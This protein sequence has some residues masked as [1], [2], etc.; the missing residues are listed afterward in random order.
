MAAA[1]QT[2]DFRFW[3]WLIR[4]VG[5]IVPRGLRADWRQ[6]WEAELRY[7][8]MMLAEWD[9]LNWQNK[10]DLFWRSL[11]AFKDALLL[12]PKRLE[13]EM[14]QDLRF[15]WR[16]LLKQKGFTA[17]AVLSLALGIGANTALFSLVDTVLLRT[18]PVGEPEQLVL[19]EWQA[20]K[21]FRTSG[22]RGTFG[23][24][25]PPGLRGASVFRFDTFEKLRQAQAAANSPLESLFAFAPI[26]ELT[27]VV[28]DQAEVIFGQAVTGGYY[29][30]LKVPAIQGRTIT[31]SDDNLAAAPVVV[32]SHQYWLERFASN[33]A[34]IGQQIKLNKHSF[35]IIG[36]TPPGFTGSGQVNQ[37]PA[38]TVPLAF[39]PTLLGDRSAQSK[40]DKP[41]V[42]WLLMMGRL[43]P[44]ATLQQAR[45]SLNGTFEA[46]A[47]EIMPPPRK[48]TE[49]AKIEAKDNP[50]LMALS[51]S[52]GAQETRRRYSTTIYG[53]FGVVAAV[54]LIACANVANLLLARAALRGPEITVRLAVGAGRWR[55]IRQLLTESVLLSMLGGAVGVIFAFW[56]K[57]ALAA[58]ADRDTAFLPEG[59]EPS[60]NWRVLLFTVVVSL[61]TG[62]LFGLA[63]AWRATR[64]DL[65]AGLKQARRTTGAVSRLSKGLVIAQVAMSLLLL[66]GAGLFIRTLHNLQQ[67]NVGFNQDN[68]LLFA[69]Q[70]RQGGY[71]DERLVQFYQ[72]LFA[73]L[74]ALPGVRAAT[75][76]A[77]PLISHFTWNTGLLLPGET[78]KGA[79]EHIA[80]RQMARENYFSTLEIPLLRGRNF[81]ETDVATSP[82]VA[83][84]NQTFAR[85]FFPD[86]DA[87]GKHVREED[88][89]RDLEIVG[90]VA[91]TKYNSQRDDIE[92]LLF[93]NWRQELDNVGEMYF[94]LRTTGEPT[95]LT[96]SVRQAV[97]ELDANLPVTEFI[98]QRARAETSLAQERLYARLLSFFGI[99]ALLL[100]AIGLSG[101]LAYSVAQRTNEIGVRMALGAQ[102]SHVLRMVIWQG[103]K[104]V[105][106]GLVTGGFVAYGLKKLLAGK[107][108]EEGSWQRQM[109]EQLYGISGNEPVTIGIIAGLL[110]LIA[111]I[112]CWLPARKAVQVDPLVALRHE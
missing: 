110:A 64:A 67:V 14:I 59:V 90:I 68:L 50:R 55:L 70:P 12:Q 30:G 87:L 31:E 22:M 73:R 101:V 79:G 93:T 69:V 98:S 38:V 11:G 56:G 46:T 10:F 107:Y 89:K 57:R 16:M 13:E 1:I 26:Y 85:K 48:D 75:F 94:A 33:P 5:L 21:P 7:R 53:L 78:V 9:L 104:L 62:L 111:L 61:L 80:N 19:F 3:L 81:A 47:L 65:A 23:G 72:Q 58:M 84:V 39:E 25:Q 52:R 63:P 24:G 45:D 17:V 42:W 43:K 28:D 95:A 109:V 92:P 6:E 34:V 4:F 86:D 41:G 88:G 105:L 112:A 40:A 97:R 83:I 76:G 2:T 102:T 51:G 100:A 66:I 106:L 96:A 35:T 60:M 15:G 91:D 103:M 36:V 49:P 27:S 18:L 71:K 82:H 32:L 44:G 37:R 108:F 99:L 29:A 74:D 54:L 77:V 8:E 20:G